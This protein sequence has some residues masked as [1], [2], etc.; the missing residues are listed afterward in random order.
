MVMTPKA[1]VFDVDGSA[2]KEEF[3]ST[4]PDMKIF[5]LREQTVALDIDLTLNYPREATLPNT[6]RK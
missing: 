3:A 2:F 5:L 6:T 4:V 1:K